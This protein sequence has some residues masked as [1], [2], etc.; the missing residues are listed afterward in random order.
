MFRNR[1]LLEWLGVLLLGCLFAWWASATK[2]TERIDFQL[3]DIATTLMVG[4]RDP[5]IVIVKVDDASL[6]RA[7]KWPWPRERQAQLI[8]RIADTGPDKIVYDVLLLEPATATGDAAMANSIDQAGNV[9][10]PH[11]FVAAQNA[12]SGI[13]PLM[14]I[15]PFAEVAAG[16]G[17][18]ALDF[19]TDGAVRRIEL[20]KP[21]QSGTFPHLTLVAHG[22]GALAPAA[23]DMIAQE[24]RPIVPLRE[25]HGYPEVH[26]SDVLDGTVPPAFLSG[27]T[28]FVGATAQGLGDTYP[29]ASLA[30][31]A[32]SG[33]E[34][35]ANLFDNLGQGR[36]VIP[37]QPALAHLL[38]VLAVIVLFIGFRGLRPNQLLGF[39]ILLAFAILGTAILL[40]L[41]SGLW[42]PPGAALAAIALS[43]PLWGWRRLASVVDFLSRES[44]NLRHI[45]ETERIDASGF[46]EVDRQSNR[47]GSLVSLVRDRFDFI[48]SVIRNVPDP[49]VVFDRNGRSIL[50]N[51]Q[52]LQ[53]FGE[54]EE[55]LALQDLIGTNKGTIDQASGELAIGE[56][57]VFTIARAPLELSSGDAPSEIVQFH[58][59]TALRAAERERRE[60]LEFLSHDMRS[61]QVA[62]IGMAD[63]KATAQ[64]D[65]DRLERIKHQAERT[66][67]LADDFVQIARMAEA[68]LRREEFDLAG[69][70]EEAADRSHFLA[71]RYGIEL[72]RQIPEEPAFVWGDPSLVA[73]VIDNLLSNAIKFSPEG[74]QVTL[75]VRASPADRRKV[76]LQIAD[77][78]P[79]LPPE[80]VNNPFR[81]FGSR[82]ESRGASAGLG[83]AFVAEAA[84]KHEADLKVVSE[85]GRGACFRLDF[86]IVQLED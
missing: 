19:E 5:S 54:G 16:I 52:A 39:T 13:E 2:V 51:E 3:Q 53:L 4:E 82:D 47:L 29:V 83:L 56:G 11:S 84:R 80:R 9:F 27:K 23:N 37:V 33:V 24:T 20:L 59:V 85:P 42:F 26:A 61:P 28:V 70:A 74:S 8:D 65:Q 48:R 10:L 66:L 25:V 46:D 76:R 40:P 72:I 17:H 14:P 68:P 12:Q 7:G 18:V 21:A 86:G 67:K 31:G 44:T 71:Q 35:Q 41:L 36:F 78:G 50:F 43:Y 79:G 22:E 45:G 58:E 73:R 49:I 77:Q 60:M 63:D 15:P 69:L 1:L 6:A 62:I 57:R 34:I 30:G 64:A 32:M 81:R 75:S 55:G 38:S